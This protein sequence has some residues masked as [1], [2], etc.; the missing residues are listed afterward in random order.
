MFGVLKLGK[1]GA[2]M[3]KAGFNPRTLFSAGEQGVWYDPSDMSTMFQDVAGTT[4]VTAVGQPVGL[5]LDKSGRGNHAF[6]AT[7][8][9]R[10]VLQ[11]DAS[12]RYYMLF[13]GT[14]DWLVT[15]SIDFT[16]TDKMT[17]FAGVRKLSDAA[18][19]AFLEL[20]ANQNT[21]A[22]AFL[23]TI[24]NGA[25]TRFAASVSEGN[26]LIYNAA[27]YTDSAAPLTNV[28][29]VYLNKALTTNEVVEIRKNGSAMSLVRSPNFN[30]TGNFGNYPLFVGRRAGTTIPFKGRLYSLIVRGAQSTEQ[31]IASAE[32]WVNT[33]TG[34]Y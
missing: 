23:I 10:P 19:G 1:L 33:K 31:Q 9:S 28:N 27:E 5:M 15:P 16:A 12:G 30:T 11:Q 14:D 7:A 34:A 24:P 21:N 8:T 32:A 20:S 25:N 6:Q 3:K 4:P 2:S 26:D 13:D 17:V 29:T 22:G 18:P